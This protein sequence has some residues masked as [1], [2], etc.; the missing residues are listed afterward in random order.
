MVAGCSRRLF[1]A[2]RIPTKSPQNP[3]KG[4]ESLLYKRGAD[5]EGREVKTQRNQATARLNED[6]IEKDGKRHQNDMERRLLFPLN[7]VILS[8]KEFRDERNY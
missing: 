8:D 5:G 7:Y 2:G 6:V 4:P 1:Y 3:P